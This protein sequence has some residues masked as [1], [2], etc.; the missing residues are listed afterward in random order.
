MYEKNSINPVI[1]PSSP[2]FYTRSFPLNPFSACLI[3]HRSTRG[4]HRPLLS[5]FLFLLVLLF[6]SVLLIT[7]ILHLQSAKRIC[8]D[9]KKRKSYVPEY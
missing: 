4:I 5:L 8:A 6:P 9:T 2:P 3:I 7:I 1:P